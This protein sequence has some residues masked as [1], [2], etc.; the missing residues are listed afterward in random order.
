M[1][2]GPW[3]VKGIDPKARLLARERAQRRGL[4]LGEYLNTLLLDDGDNAAEAPAAEP[5]TRDFDRLD[6]SHLAHGRL[7][8]GHLDHDPLDQGRGGAAAGELHRMSA[9]IDTLTQRLEATQARTARSMAGIDKSIVGLMSKVDTSGKAQLGALERV[10]RAMH[11]IET[12]QAALRTRIETLETDDSAAP[13][14]SALRSLETSLGRLAEAVQERLEAVDDRMGR[15]TDRLDGHARGMD[16]VDHMESQIASVERRV[17]GAL[18]RMNDA[19]QRL[20]HFESKA[21]RAAQDSSWRMER[22]IENALSRS[23]QMSKEVADRVEAMEEKTREAVGS[24]GDAV[25]RITERLSRAERKHDTV[26]DVLQQSVSDIDERMSRLGSGGDGLGALQ[27]RLETLAEDLSRPMHAMRQDVERRIEEAARSAGQPERLERLERS[28]RQVQDQLQESEARQSTLLQTVNAQT[29]RL[30]RTV[31]ERL[32]AAEAKEG[33]RTIETVRRE[34]TALADTIEKRLA[35]AERDAR[36]A[37]ET[38]HEVARLNDQVSRRFAEAEERT[39][40]LIDEVGSQVTSVADRLQRRHDESIQRVMT[41][42][43]EQHASGLGPVD[44][45]RLAERLD[46]RVRDSERR[47]AEAIGQ[48]GEQVARVADRLQ[49]QHQES[50]RA[51]EARLAESDRSHETRLSEVLGDMSRRMEEIGEQ[52]AS[53]LSPVHKTLSSI[54][55]RIE[56]LEDGEPSHDAAPLATMAEPVASMDDDDL[57]LIDDA[58]NSHDALEDELLEP[59]AEPAE[60][61]F[62]DETDIVG[63]EPPPFDAASE[64]QLFEPKLEIH[65]GTGAKLPEETAASAEPAK[66]IDDL[67]DM[68]DMVFADTPPQTGREFV[69]ELPADDDRDRPS[70]AYLAEARKAA[71]QG[72]RYESDSG[73]GRK[74]IGRGPL[75][76]SAALAVAVAGGGAWTVLRGKQDASADDF[77]RLDPSS[78]E[79]AAGDPEAAAAMLFPDSEDGAI[80]EPA[81]EVLDTAEAAAPVV[82]AGAAAVVTPEASEPRPM[83]LAEAVLDGDAVALHDQAL[84]L[85]QA[86]DKQRGHALMREAA[87][88]GLVIAQYRLAKLHERGE[89]VPRDIAASRQWTEKAAIGGNVNAMHDLAV[90]YAEGDG[91]PQSYA[92]AVEWFRQASDLGLVDSQYNLAVLYEQGLGVSQDKVEAAFWFEIAGRAGDTDAQRRARALM[93]ELSPADAEILRRK[94]RTFSPRTPVSY[95]NGEL[96]AR[97][98][99]T[100]SQ[101]QISEMQRLLQRMGYSIGTPD[102]KPGG[103]TAEAIR[104]FQRDNDLP[105]TGEPSATLL[106]Q[107][108]AASLVSAG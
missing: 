71:R 86:G 27:K 67:L 68:N 53:A 26:A 8:Q 61:M 54:A 90:F 43:E 28:F 23:R 103:R 105:V 106:R 49:T 60:G 56:A 20:E 10:A 24:L 108:K 73:N 45:D 94:A 16:R 101:A 91:G 36:A 78:P 81:R 38:R 5:Q 75:I 64:E 50:L 48:I 33:A 14:M 55:R 19:A 3:S 100:V 87:N 70:H 93:G 97:A 85:L 77:A 96:G 99:E 58:P 4:T 74:G 42:M 17:D 98:W 59:Q 88:K 57:V 83:T 39:V 31:D 63:V 2:Q 104:Q 7:D 89:G 69:G 82:Q 62:E 40:G 80:V 52:S 11:E 12:T 35:A 79:A 29:E 51:L 92:A 102:G 13:T 21:E 15:F 47:S 46:E 95:A 65:V 32:A 44:F 76:A 22:A 72:R 9:E 18:S 34:M 41:R 6:R 1:T 37:T 84:E 25:A 66:Q 30:S 107:I